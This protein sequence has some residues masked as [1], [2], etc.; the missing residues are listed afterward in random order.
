MLT[1]TG[2]KVL[3]FGLAALQ[4]RGADRSAA[5]PRADGRRAVDVGGDAPRHHSSTWRPSGSRVARPTRARHL[6]AFGAVMYEM[7]TGRRA[8]DSGSAAGV[9]AAVLQTDPPPASSIEPA[10]PA[11]FEWVIQ[12][13]IAKNPDARWQAA[14]DIV[15]IL[16]WVARTPDV[17]PPGQ[18]SKRWL[19]PGLGVLSA[20]VAV[21]AFGADPCLPGRTGD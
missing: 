4:D 13:A 5:R 12:K 19:L 16:R 10:V 6:F 9:I 8:F 15:E 17:P 11:T 1:K 2:V 7:A 3:D 20:V 21:S 14:G 18:S